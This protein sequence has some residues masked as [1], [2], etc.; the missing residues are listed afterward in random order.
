MEE[1]LRQLLSGVTPPLLLNVPLARIV[2]TVLAGARLRPAKI[3]LQSQ[4]PLL[5]QF[6]YYEQ[7]SS[8]TRERP[9][10]HVAG[11][12][13]QVPEGVPVVGWRV[14]VVVL[15]R[16]EG[17]EHPDRVLLPLREG[18]LPARVGLDLGRTT[19]LP[20]PVFG[21]QFDNLC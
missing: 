17:V 16:Q 8:L 13:P 2:A 9:E 19:F 11:N 6:T 20:D 1:F 10:H 12:V 4:V 15:C 18:H 5:K 14:I 3:I 7:N 21:G